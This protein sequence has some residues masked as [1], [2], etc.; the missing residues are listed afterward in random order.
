ME[1]VS[2]LVEILEQLWLE[3]WSD[4]HE[5]LWKN[6]RG[7][8]KELLDGPFTFS[9]DERDQRELETARF[10]F[11]GF[12]EA[13]E[14]A[15]EEGHGKEQLAEQADVAAELGLL[16]ESLYRR[17]SA[18]Y[19]SGDKV[20][21][22]IICASIATVQGRLSQ[23]TLADLVEQSL[24][25]FEELSHATETDLESQPE[26]VEAAGAVL[27]RLGHAL[28]GLADW[29]RGSNESDGRAHLYTLREVA[30]FGDEFLWPV[31]ELVREAVRT[32]V[33][34]DSLARFAQDPESAETRTELIR[35][36]DAYV[37]RTST[38]PVPLELRDELLDELEACRAALVEGGSPEELQELAVDLVR[39]GQDIEAERYSLDCLSVRDFKEEALLLDALVRRRIPAF[40]VAGGFQQNDW[41]QGTKKVIAGFVQ[42]ELAVEEVL[43]R[44]E[45]LVFAEEEFLNQ[46]SWYR[47]S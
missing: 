18:I 4:A 29:A 6:L 21:D 33:M 23:V 20:L 15:L 43:A 42:G 41:S 22:T 14:R 11:A 47:A 10:L 44:I 2:G 5:E 13:V 25:Y 9:Y 12:E 45:E 1:V 3:Q 46:K 35:A 28:L 19:F 37:E 27:D 16:V 39:L 7:G 24:P 31:P 32:P 8:L 17:R 30:E 38:I 26:L 34:G 40:V 36:L